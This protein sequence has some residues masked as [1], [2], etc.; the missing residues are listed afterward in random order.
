M[1][2]VIISDCLLGTPCRFDGASK[3]QEFVIELSKKVTTT[4]VCPERAGGLLSPRPPAEQQEGRVIDREGK[5]VTAQFEAGTRRTLAHAEKSGARL[6]ILKAKSP[7]CGSGRIYDG[8]FTGTLVPGW[9]TAARAL[10][11]KGFV[12]I[13][14]KQAQ[15]CE[16]TREHP[17]AIVCGSGF[18][19]LAEAI[20]VQE[21]IPYEDIPGFRPSNWQVKGHTQKALRGTL[22]GVPV[23]LYPGRI[24]VYQG[25][26]AFESTLL[27]RH[28][29]SLG[30]R[31][32]VLTNASGAVNP[33]IQAGQIGLITDH[34][35][36]TGANPL[37][38]PQAV[39]MIPTAFVSL[40]DAYSPYLG[41]LAQGVAQDLGIGLRP[42]VYTGLT[43]PSYETRA[44]VRMLH[45]SGSDL[46]GMSTVHETI[47]ARALGMSVLGLSVAANGAGE[48]E[49]S[50]EE[51]LRVTQAAAKDAAA[52][53]AGTLKLLCTE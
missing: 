46:V 40:G 24:H 1:V 53:V 11:E 51:V 32:V 7:S 21:E 39:A 45:N 43:G 5:D 23:I 6:A 15:D 2:R 22:E 37:L 44:E 19:A 9:G 14:E 48:I 49:L 10:K 3:P 13:D 16:I 47:M 33:D 25:Y 8:T 35:N 27:V 36:L 41:A 38:D 34:I 31:V 18:G 52:I 17:C 12:V 28:A 4:P 50:H 20:E 42:V 26:S 30:A 29:H